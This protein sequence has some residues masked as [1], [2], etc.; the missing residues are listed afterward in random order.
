MCVCLPFGHIST[1]LWH[2]ASSYFHTC[3]YPCHSSVLFKFPAILYSFAHSFLLH[4]ITLPVVCILAPLILTSS[5]IWLTLVV[6]AAFVFCFCALFCL[7][8]HLRL[9]LQ[10][11]L[12]CLLVSL[13]CLW[14]FHIPTPLAS[15]PLPATKSLQ[16]NLAV[17]LHYLHTFLLAYLFTCISIIQNCKENVFLS[18][19]AEHRLYSCTL[20]A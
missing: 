18:K 7:C 14:P 20:L 11:I 3:L 12:L 17:F 1:C 5:H 4:C 13:P 19:H 8:V 15:A 16:L 9:Q 10:L 2:F 6:L